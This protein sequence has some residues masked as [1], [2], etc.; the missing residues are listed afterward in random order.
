VQPLLQWK[1]NMYY[2][3]WVC[4]CSL[5]YPAC[6]VHV[7]YCHLWP[8]RLY[9]I[10]THSLIKG[11]IFKIK[12]LNIKCVFWFSLQLL[13]ATFWDVFAKM[14]NTSI[15]FI[16]SVCPSF[17]PYGKTRLPLD[18]FLLNWVY[19]SKIVHKNQLA[20][21]SENNNRYFT[22]RPLYNF[23]HS[24]FLLRMRIF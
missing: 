18:W 9:N 5:S 12:L 20:W 24:S 14:R 21:T 19:F 22:W 3:I 10:L 23:D 11:M 16:V 1:S 6:T 15:S 13:S 4:I 17:R 2:I 8:V 7:L